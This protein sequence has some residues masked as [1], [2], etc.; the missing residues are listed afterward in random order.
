YFLIHLHIGEA[1]THCEQEHTPAQKPAEGNDYRGKQV[2]C[3]YQ[4]KVKRIV[5]DHNEHQ[6]SE[7]QHNARNACYPESGNDKNLESDQDYPNQKCNDLPILGKAVKVI[8]NQIDDERN[9]SRET[10]ETEAG[11]LQF[12]I[13]TGYDDEDQQTADEWVQHPRDYSLGLT[14]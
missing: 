12:K 6:G 8:G 14:K 11:C 13:N 1:R 10:G 3:R 2:A 5:I 4:V 7:H 9:Q